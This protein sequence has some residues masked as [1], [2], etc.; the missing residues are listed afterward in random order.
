[1]RDTLLAMLRQF[2]LLGALL[3]P[4]QIL[5]PLRPGQPL[6][7]RGTAADLL[8]FALD[9]LL[10]N[11]G[12]ALLLAGLATGLSWLVPAAV[13]ASFGAQP[14]GVQLAEI[15][16]LSELGGYAAHRLAHRSALLWRFHAVHHSAE[17]LDWLA[18]HRQ[19]PVEAVWL[20]GVANLPALVLGFS[21]APLAWFVL[22]QK[23]YTG[24]LHANVRLGFG[25]LGWLLASPEFHHRHHDAEAGLHATNF[26]TLLPIFDRLFGTHAKGRGF[27]VRYGTDTPVPAGYVGQLLSPLRSRQV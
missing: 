3:T 10:I 25:R 21:L 12:A 20:L 15:L 19:H 11:A 9:P 27:P 6:W 14:W 16:L 18:A 7:R 24:L 17:S 2:F 26:A 22:L 23:V 13:R 8:H 4:L 1:M 5:L